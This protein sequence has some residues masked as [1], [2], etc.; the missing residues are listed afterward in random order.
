ML[1]IA[2]LGVSSAGETKRIKGSSASADWKEGFYTG[3]EIAKKKTK[4]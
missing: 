1:L 2:D 3:F 4:H